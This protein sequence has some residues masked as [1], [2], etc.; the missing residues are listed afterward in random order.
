MSSSKRHHLLLTNDDGIHAEGLQHLIDVLSHWGMCADCPQ[1]L[2]GDDMVDF[3]DVLMILSQ[4]GD[5][6]V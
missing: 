3:S 6:P 2:N 5:C 1:D 4:W